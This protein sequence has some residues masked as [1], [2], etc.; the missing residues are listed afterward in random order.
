M[1]LKW[2]RIGIHAEFC[3]EIL[4]DNGHF[5][6][7]KGTLKPNVKMG[8]HVV[9]REGSKCLILEK[10]VENVRIL[11]SEFFLLFECIC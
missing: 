7:R 6:V 3:W 8:K 10:A 2:D 11:V 1:W 4:A 5:E 9:V